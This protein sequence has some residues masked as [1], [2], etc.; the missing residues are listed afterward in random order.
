M[1]GIAIFNNPTVSA[2]FGAVI[3]ALI[4]YGS[5]ILLSRRQSFNEAAGKFHASFVEA[6]RLLQEN[7]TFDIT[8][9][10]GTRVKTILEGYI[11]EHERAMLIF[12]PYVPK[13]K[14]RGF[15]KAWRT[16]YSQKNKYAECLSEYDFVDDYDGNDKG[17]KR[18]MAL[19]RIDQLLKF[20][21]PK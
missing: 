4:T 14:L 19:D 16:Y 11:V 6:Q 21:T 1:N 18:K 20:A 10:G 9:P 3:G 8:V 15:D 5:F 17:E 2:I 13:R 12:R 7:K